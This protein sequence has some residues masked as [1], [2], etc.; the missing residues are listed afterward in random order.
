MDKQRGG[1]FTVAGWLAMTLLALCALEAVA[2]R[3][4]IT[5]RVVQLQVHVAD[6]GLPAMEIRPPKDDSYVTHVFPKNRETC[7]SYDT[8]CYTRI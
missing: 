3:Y 4:L 2:I 1:S 8:I 5:H 7:E 6:R